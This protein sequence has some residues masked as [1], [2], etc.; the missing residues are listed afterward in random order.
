MTGIVHRPEAN[1][2]LSSFGEPEPD[3]VMIIYFPEHERLVRELVKGGCCV[4]G[5]VVVL[6]L[7]G[8]HLFAQRLQIPK[9]FHYL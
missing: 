1:L 7:Q 3:N 6:W 4:K 9:M 5:N 8:G 2:P